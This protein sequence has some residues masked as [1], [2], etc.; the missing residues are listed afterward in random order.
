MLASR[1]ASRVTAATA[2]TYV[3]DQHHASSWQPGSEG[4][5]IRLVLHEYQRQGGPRRLADLHEYRYQ[6]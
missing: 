3:R 2:A 6:P 4:E 1:T 5:P